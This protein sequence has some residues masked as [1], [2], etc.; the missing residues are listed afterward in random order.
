[1]ERKS[2]GADELVGRILDGRYRIGPSIARGGMAT[3]YEATDLRLDRTVA[4]KVMHAAYTNEEDFIRRFQREARSAARLSQDNVVSVFDTGDDNGVLYLVMEYV[5]GLTLR[6]AIRKEA[7]M[8][9]LK[10]L[11][12]I[13]PVL[14]A[15]S[16]AHRAGILHR[17]I[18]PENVL[19]ADDGRVKVT[20]FGLARAINSETQHTATGG[21]L[22]G[23]VSYL[24]PEIVVNK[25]I[26]ARADVYAAG[27]LIYELLTGRKPHQADSPI[28]VAYKHVNEDIPPPSAVIPTIPAY[29]DAL[30]SRATARDASL[31]PADAGVLLHQVRRV[32]NALEQ[33]VTS[34][35]EL[36]GDLYP[37]HHRTQ[38]LERRA[39]RG[40]DAPAPDSQTDPRDQV[41]DYQEVDTV[42]TPASS[43]IPQQ[44]PPRSN[45]IPAGG[46]G[47]PESPQ[48]SGGSNRRGPFLLLAVL[49][50]AGLVGYAGWYLGMGRYQQT[51]SVLD[52]TQSAATK[53]LQNSGLKLSVVK[54]A[55][56]EEVPAGRVI[57]TDPSPSE[58]VLKNG[59]VRA[60]LSL[61]PERHPVPDLIQK[62]VDEATDLLEEATLA[63]GTTTEVFSETIPKGQVVAVE[64]GVGTPLKRGDEVTLRVSKGRKPIRIPDFTNRAWERAQ[65]RLTRLGFTPQASEDYSNSVPR[66]NVI[67]Q[68]PNSGTGFR[69]ETINLVVSRGP[70]LVAVPGVI[71]SGLEAAT[72]TLEQAGFKVKVERSSV[73]V[74]LS[75]VVGQS[76]DANSKAPIGSTITLSIV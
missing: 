70:Q 75:Y 37:D 10:A 62:P 38:T 74:G 66:G 51:P 40:V 39:D 42:S 12:L 4:I 36:E 65:K 6:D 56:D 19:L 55:Y 44:T 57:S 61:G 13:D 3:V 68:S 30:V 5:P 53:K 9:P 47:S 16:A 18:K 21:V 7:P 28:Q 34:D 73:Y 71:G 25:P 43:S 2:G 22:I 24:A 11:S 45:R 48:S 29:V 17:D 67:S 50:L 49:L 1:M 8:S 63:V 20:D 14:E 60:V 69:G 72:K 32:R 52:L 54:K 35:S 46:K 58:K 64:P 76:P 33:G 15:L 23:T 26:D 59:T 31:R 27:V 41:F